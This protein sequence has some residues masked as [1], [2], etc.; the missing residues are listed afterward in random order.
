MVTEKGNFELGEIINLM[1]H[2]RKKEKT[3]EYYVDLQGSE[4]VLVRT[5]GD[6]YA[7]YIEAGKVDEGAEDEYIARSVNEA[8]KIALRI[9]Q[10]VSDAEETAADE[11]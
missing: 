5:A 6:I 9:E 8:L 11:Q 2:R 7:A 4:K 3:E 1:N 10:L